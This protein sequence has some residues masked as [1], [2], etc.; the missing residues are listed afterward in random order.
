M[1]D[2]LLDHRKI[3]H[4]QRLFFFS[5]H[6]P[7]SAF[8]LPNGVKIYNKL[9]QLLRDEYFNRDYNEVMTPVIAKDSL[10]K[11]SGH[12]DK[13]KENM[14]CLQC[15]DESESQ[16]ALSAMN[17]PKHCIMFKHVPRSYKELP[18]RFADFGALHR[19]ELTGSLTGLTRVRKFHQDDAHIFVTRS[20]IKSEIKD[21]LDFITSI[22]EKFGFKFEIGL[23]TRPDNYIGDIN[24]W[25][26][27]EQ[28]LKEILD[29]SKIE[30]Y[31]KEKDGAFYGCKI[32]IQ[33]TDSLGRK[34]QCATIQLDFN[35]PNE[36]KLEYV[37]ENG[38]FEQPVMIHRAIYGSF[39]RFM[40][41][42]CE[43]YQGKFPFWLN[44]NQVIIIPISDKFID[45]SNKLKQKLRS[46]KYCVDVDTSTNLLKEKIYNAQHNKYNY[47]LIVGQNEMDNETVS[48]RYRDNNT[49]K[50]VS[51]SD[52][53]TELKENMKSFK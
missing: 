12:W 36:F 8:F 5:E 27:A 28:Q 18:L 24:L 14:F 49:K 33:L 1:V 32:D 40:A 9:Q 20:Q 15:K 21:C 39:E 23:S 10:W 4:D 51:I 46:K 26:E 41:I 43:H 38:K 53:L 52:L 35:L 7:G 2:N 30:Y 17:C 3:G 13:Y 48:I 50:N 19:N 6:S 44:Y 34:H 31:V 29:E 42:L 11:I 47:I 45:Y 37:D 25:N 16:Y 22:Y